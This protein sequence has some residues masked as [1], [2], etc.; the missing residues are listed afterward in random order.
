MQ[1]HT[2]QLTGE[3]FL[4]CEEKVFYE[5]GMSFVRSHF[6]LWRQ[7]LLALSVIAWLLWKWDHQQE[8]DWILGEQQQL[9]PQSYLGEP[10]AQ[11]QASS[12]PCSW[13]TAPS[14][15]SHYKPKLCTELVASGWTDRQKMEAK[16]PRSGKALFEWAFNCPQAES[17]KFSD[18]VS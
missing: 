8:L 2:D 18:S 17:S 3:T 15:N 1:S 4:L 6:P 5:S 10:V 16:E 7:H 12:D 14:P 9:D 13:K 11:N